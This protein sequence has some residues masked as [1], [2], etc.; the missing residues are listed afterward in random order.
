MLWDWL[1]SIIQK[2]LVWLWFQDTES[3]VRKKMAAVHFTTMPCEPST[4]YKA[5]RKP[6]CLVYTIFVPVLMTLC[7]L[8]LKIL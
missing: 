1:R 5:L 2:Q 4:A 3:T 7:S 8:G 6:N